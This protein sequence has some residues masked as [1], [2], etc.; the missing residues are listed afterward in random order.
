MD[1]TFTAED[2]QF[3]A[4]VSAWLDENRPTSRL[5]PPTTPEG[6]RQHL[7]WERRLFE[8]GF[9]APGWPEEFG[10]L[11][12]DLWGETVFDEEYV[13]R[14][15]PERLN[16]MALIHGARTVMA[17]G[18][19]EQ[20]ARWL[21]GV[22]D[23]SDIWCQGFSE[24]G[25][26]SDLAAI[27][28]T[29]RIEGDE[30][31]LDGQKTWT[32]NG[33]IATRMYALI[34]T[35]PRAS[36]H[37]GISFVVFD[38]DI[39][40]VEIRPM[41]QLHGNSGFAEVFFTGARIP[42]SSVVGGLGDG[43]RVAQTA[44]KLERGASRGSHTRLKGHLDGLVTVVDQAGADRALTERLGAL[45]SW[46]Y[47]YVQSTYALTDTVA[48]GGDEGVAAS[49]NKLRSTELQTAIGEL[50][51]EIL[52]AAGPVVDE[53]GP[54]GELGGFHRDYWHGRA[55]EI[56]AGTSEIQKNI[57]AERGLGLPREPTA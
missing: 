8:A 43:W 29:G 26:G 53:L 27:R 57:I 54:A 14:R 4:R 32:S 42:V 52:G 2:E 12:L 36:K 45:R 31:V 16:K 28:T 18:T 34:R 33:A 1:L 23:C 6:F 30:I 48:R 15:L 11:G 21:P 7:D 56:F 40:G 5:L 24:P 10:G 22:L 9:A 17:H 50:R 44:L 19:A 38:L 37:R 13:A 20:K 51:L 35:D 49:I 25:A 41:R 39:D 3:R 46:V 55:A 47:A